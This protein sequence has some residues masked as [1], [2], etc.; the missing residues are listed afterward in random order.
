MGV[1]QSQRFFIVPI[2]PCPGPRKQLQVLVASLPWCHGKKHPRDVLHST[3][4]ASHQGPYRNWEVAFI[5]SAVTEESPEPRI[6][7]PVAAR[8]SGKYSEHKKPRASSRKS[9]L[10]PEAAGAM[11]SPVLDPSF[12]GSLTGSST[13]PF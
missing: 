3:A 5:S 2:P 11:K 13:F 10:G 12:G 1:P 4:T 6:L 9:P 8:A 7:L